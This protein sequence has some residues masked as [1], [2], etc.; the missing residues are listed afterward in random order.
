MHLYI[1]HISLSLQN[2]SEQHFVLNKDGDLGLL[3]EIQNFKKAERTGLKQGSKSIRDSA[4]RV[5][6]CC[7]CSSFQSCFFFFNL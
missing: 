1:K 2:V 4:C 5:V 6:L 7:A 3:V